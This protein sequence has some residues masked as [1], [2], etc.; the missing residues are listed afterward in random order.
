MRFVSMAVPPLCALAGLQIAR[1]PIER[2]RPLAV[3][4][5]IMVLWSAMTAVNYVLEPRFAD[6]LSLLQILY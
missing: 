1:L 5:A 4:G 6:V 2:A 3:V